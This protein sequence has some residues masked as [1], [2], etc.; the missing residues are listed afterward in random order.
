MV[1]SEYVEYHQLN[2]GDTI[3]SSFR[4]KVAGLK[5]L[6]HFIVYLGDGKAIHNMPVEGVSLVSMEEVANHYREV[7]RIERFEGGDNELQLLYERAREVL[8]KPYDLLSFNCES[9]ANYLRY[10]KATS[11]QVIAFAVMLVLAVI[12]IIAFVWG[13]RKMMKNNGSRSGGSSGGTRGST[14]I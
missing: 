8:G 14:Y 5:S 13:F 2:P 9:L 11:K 3:V 6:F 1:A 10:G 7:H 12:A 4:E